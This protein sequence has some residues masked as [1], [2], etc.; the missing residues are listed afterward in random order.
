MEIET[1]NAIQLFFPNPSLVQ[2]YFEAI[3]N[4]FDA[5]ASEINIKIEITK[6]SQANSLRITITDNGVGFTDISFERFERLLKPQ[7]SLHKGL[8]RLVYLHY[9]S[10][11]E[12]TSETEDFRREFVF[13]EVFK[14]DSLK[15]QKSLETK[16]TELKFSAFK[17]EKIKSY[18][19]LR[20]S[21]LK[22][23]IIG[24]F[25][26]YLYYRKNQNIEFL[27]KIELLTEESNSTK[28][29]FSDTETISLK[30]L[31]ELKKVL[32]SDVTLD[33]FDGIEMSYR[34]KSGMGEREKLIAVCIDGRTIPIKIISE[35]AI[36]FN[37]SVIFLFSSKL[38]EGKADSSRQRLMLPE[39][40][41]EQDLFRILRREVGKV[42][43]EEIV[44]IAEKNKTTTEDFE[45][46]FPHLLGYFE[47]TTAGLI[48]KNEAIDI[49]QKKFFKE[50]KEI[51]ECESLDDKTFERSLNISARTLTE[52]ILYRELIL[53]KLSQIDQAAK[54]S[55]IHNLIVPRYK[56]FT[57]DTLIED[58]YSNNAW[59]LDDKFMSFTTILSEAR[60]DTLIEAIA[61][62]SDPAKDEGRPD[63]SMI[64]SANPDNATAVDVVIVEIK[65]KTDDDK[66]NLY[67]ATQLMKRARKLVNHCPNI[68]RIWYYAVIEINAELSQILI[69]TKWAPLFSKGH[70]FYQDFSIQAPDGR[71]IPTP[72]HILSFDAILNDA[73]VRN[74]TFLEI[75][76][77]GL[78][79]HAKK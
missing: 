42:L 66:E 69:D 53:K 27:I 25:L 78:K 3:A 26:P 60:M 34:I 36:P 11:I 40:I 76:K 23:L 47:N 10:K 70:V 12:F 19:D 58:I 4:A 43:S 45:K 37:Y 74:S 61:I 75:L 28:D 20:P 21:A 30:D 46:K 62:D 68:Q 55:E 52:Y 59:L 39:D 65:K 6:F 64:F 41:S 56:T 67:A 32:I 31:P 48:D 72:V 35:N 71:K 14:G 51:L 63:I 24:Q 54:E 57:K 79:D 49:A 17:N 44:E 8:G 5:S 9:F 7:D 13:D 2:V 77:R 1:N 38:F 15:L 16:E 18:N 29:F 73:T 22:N 33:Q 50:Q